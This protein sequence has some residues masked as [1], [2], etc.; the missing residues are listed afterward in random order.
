MHVTRKQCCLVINVNVN[1]RQQH[2]TCGQMA[3][4]LVSGY[5]NKSALHKGILLRVQNE[6]DI[7]L[8]GTAVHITGRNPFYWSLFCSK[9]LVTPTGCSSFLSPV[10]IGLY[11]TQEKEEIQP[12]HC[13]RL[14]SHWWWIWSGLLHSNPLSHKR[15]T[16]LGPLDRLHVCYLHELHCRFDSLNSKILAKS[17]Q[18]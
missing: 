18:E 3:S 11:P 12:S 14:H 16:K 9:D 5:A 10:L 15:K 2:I 13:Q 4:I 1:I 7:L 6:S 17:L 8:I